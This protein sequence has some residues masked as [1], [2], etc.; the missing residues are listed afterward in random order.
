MV[1]PYLAK[2]HELR[3]TIVDETIFACRIDSQES[4]ATAVDWRHDVESS[5]H[6]LVTLSEEECGRFHVLM[7]AAGLRYAAIDLVHTPDDRTYFL[8]LNPE[9]QFGWIEAMTGAPIMSALAKGLL[10]G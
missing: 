9:G 7:R 2:A 3:V 10:S 5:P 4:E 8:D 6:R 1:Q